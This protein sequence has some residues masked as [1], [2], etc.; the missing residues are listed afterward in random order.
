MWLSAAE[1]VLGFKKLPQVSAEQHGA[2][3]G[4][5]GYR[6]ANCD[7]YGDSQIPHLLTATTEVGHQRNDFMRLWQASRGAR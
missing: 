4:A 1:R 6:I 2:E 5:P 7:K 3:P